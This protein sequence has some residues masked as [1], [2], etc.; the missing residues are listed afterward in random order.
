MTR[1]QLFLSFDKNDLISRFCSID[2]RG[3]ASPSFPLLLSAFMRRDSAIIPTRETGRSEIT[4]SS[5][6]DKQLM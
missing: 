5:V 2:G 4:L 3:V 6:S 1:Y